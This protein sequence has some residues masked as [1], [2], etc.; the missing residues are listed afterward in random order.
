MVLPLHREV[1]CLWSF[2][3]LGD[4][5]EFSA[6]VVDVGSWDG[7]CRERRMGKQ[8]KEAEVHEQLQSL[9]SVRCNGHDSAKC[10][11]GAVCKKGYCG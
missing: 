1:F 6:C 8:S 5:T 10:L 9:C 2:P 3:I 7:T 4:E 11:H